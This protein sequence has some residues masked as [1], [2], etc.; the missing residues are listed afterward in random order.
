VYPDRDLLFCASLLQPKPSIT[1]A[2]VSFDVSI[3]KRMMPQ[4]SAGC[5]STQ[6]VVFS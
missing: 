4:R 5:V 3:R 6:F 2:T 1:R